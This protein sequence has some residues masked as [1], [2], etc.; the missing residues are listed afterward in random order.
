M[1]PSVFFRV[2]A[3]PGIGL[4]HLQRCLSLATALAESG[5]QVSFLVNDARMAADRVAAAGFP[6]TQLSDV[7]SWSIAD[8]SRL[9]EEVASRGASTVVVDSDLKSAT[10]MRKVRAAGVTLCAIEDN[11]NDEV[12]AHLL[13]NGDAHAQYQKYRSATGDTEVVLG[14][15]YAPLAAPYA[16]YWTSGAGSE[17][18]VPPRHLLVT[19]GGSDPHGLMPAL[20]RAAGDAPPPLQ[21]HVVVGPFTGR[22]E[23]IDGALRRLSRRAIVHMAPA[24]MFPIISAC[25]LALS[26]A[27]Q[28]LYELAACGRPAV[29]IEAAVNQRR[30]LHEFVSSGAVM[31]AGAATDAG[32]AARAVS[33]ATALAGQPD[34]LRAMAAAG[35]AFID[36]QG[37]RR[38]ARR[39]LACTA[40]RTRH[41]D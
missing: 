11:D 8:A 6:V 23:E 18:A 19:L 14:P 21:L 33:M 35:P 2:D 1:K 27:G 15:A 26:A 13:L 40:M 28:T 5:S 3:G 29:A 30:Q 41:V 38:A 12:V 32:I 37:A 36:G 16:D 25:D 20:I 31:R 34:V 22:E 17:A 24:S 4:G 10:Y 9:L 39:L 7:E